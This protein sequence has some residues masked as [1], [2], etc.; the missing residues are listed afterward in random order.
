MTWA[1]EIYYNKPTFLVKK[2]NY[3]GTN[4]DDTEYISV[5][6]IN[7]V[8]HFYFLSFKDDQL[9]KVKLVPCCLLRCGIISGTNVIYAQY[10]AA[11]KRS[12]HVN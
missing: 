7:K 1:L 12:D 4:L 5:K 10:T 11:K 8:L 2:H 9:A 6:A 3:D